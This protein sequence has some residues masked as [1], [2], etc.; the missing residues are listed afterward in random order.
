MT[1]LQRQRLGKSAP[2]AP[3]LLWG[4]VGDDVIPI[5]QIRD[6]RD[7][8][9]GHG[10]NVQY[11]EN[12]LPLVPGNTAIGHIIPMLAHLDYVSTWIWDQL[13]PNGGTKPNWK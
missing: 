2:Q 3:T 11:F 12:E 1:E 13:D 9:R 8:W 7:D 4:G 6:L 10:G 5:Q